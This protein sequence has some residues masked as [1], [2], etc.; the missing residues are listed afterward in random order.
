ME[1]ENIVKS[2][3]LSKKDSFA[4]FK[5]K[6]QQSQQFIAIKQLKKDA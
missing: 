3:Q 2:R 4:M 6:S 1:I 5:K